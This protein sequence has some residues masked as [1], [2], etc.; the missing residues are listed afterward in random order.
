MLTLEDA[1]RAGGLTKLGVRGSGLLSL[2]VHDP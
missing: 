1:L 2:L